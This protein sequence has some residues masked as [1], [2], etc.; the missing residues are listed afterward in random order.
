VNQTIAPYMVDPDA[1]RSVAI[2]A[3]NTGS[4][5]QY[6]VPVVRARLTPARAATLRPGLG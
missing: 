1:A 3:D 6:T 5:M 2:W 4:D